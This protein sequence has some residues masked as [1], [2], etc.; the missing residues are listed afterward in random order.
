M[1]QENIRWVNKCSILFLHL[2]F[3]NEILWS[4]LSEILIYQFLEPEKSRWMKGIKKKIQ[5]LVSQVED[6]MI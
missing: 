3:A 5:M 4:H 2:K 1:N 6:I